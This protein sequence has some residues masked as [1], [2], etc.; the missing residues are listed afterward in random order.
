[1]AGGTRVYLIWAPFQHKH[2]G[3]QEAWVQTTVWSFISWWA[4]WVTWTFRFHF[5]IWNRL[6]APIGC[7]DTNCSSALCTSQ[8]HSLNIYLLSP[9][10]QYPTWSAKAREEAVKK[11]TK[12]IP[13]TNTLCPG[14]EGCNS[15]TFLTRMQ[16]GNI[17]HFGESYTHQQT[18]FCA[19]LED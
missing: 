6:T 10:I 18:R 1:M 7:C 19:W 2:H 5:F 11:K 4:W 13:G 3:S 8:R 17:R 15:Q 14:Q 12:K 9:F 16:F